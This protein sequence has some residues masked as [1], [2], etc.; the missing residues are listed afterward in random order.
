MATNVF[1]RCTETDSLWWTVGKEYE[2]DHR[3]VIDDAGD[4]FGLRELEIMISDGGRRPTGWS[5]GFQRI[6]RNCFEANGHTWF[7]HVPG[8]PRPCDGGA[9]V[10]LLLT[11][12]G[13]TV[14]S[15]DLPCGARCIEWRSS[16]RIVGWRFADS[17]KP[18]LPGTT[19][20]L[21][22]YIE[23][24]EDMGCDEDAF[25][26]VSMLGRDVSAIEDS[27]LTPSQRRH[28]EEMEAKQAAREQLKHDAEAK[29]LQE[30]AEQLAD[31]GK[32]MDRVNQGHDHRY[33]A[34]AYVGL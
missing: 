19:A 8:D 6:E 22:E 13:M 7:K 33:G 32:A 5:A 34:R 21:S 30:R 3:G 23:C 17:A 9:S 28:W 1:Y 20:D 31:A 14:K 4:Y 27:T 25:D 10:Y 24:A 16:T 11:T 18:Y 12:P 2:A 15:S 29:A 26:Q